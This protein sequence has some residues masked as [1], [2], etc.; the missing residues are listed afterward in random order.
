MLRTNVFWTTTSCR[1]QFFITLRRSTSEKAL[2][3]FKL[4]QARMQRDD[5]RPVYLKAG[6]RDKILFNATAVMVLAAALRSIYII[7][8]IDKDS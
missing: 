4:K 5:G 1:R 2:Q 6:I 8:K 7:W 3:K